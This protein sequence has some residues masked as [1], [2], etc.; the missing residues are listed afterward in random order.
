MIVEVGSVS[1]IC[2]FSIFSRSNSE[3]GFGSV[4][5]TSTTNDYFE[6][7]S[8]VLCQGIL[9]KSYHFLVSLFIFTLN[10]FSCWQSLDFVD[11]VG[12]SQMP[13]VHMNGAEW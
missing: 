6:R 12:A 4:S 11:R 7:N 9:W 1:M 5:L 13:H 2:L 10:L 8:L 3:S